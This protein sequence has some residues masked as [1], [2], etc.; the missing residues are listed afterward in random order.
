[1]LDVLETRDK[2]AVIAW[3]A[4]ARDSGLLAQLEEVTTDMWEGYGTAVREALGGHI[5]IVVDRFHVM[6]HF[7]DLLVRARREIQHTLPKEA[8]AALKGSRWLWVTNAE[9]LTSEQREQLDRLKRQFPALGL[10]SEHRDQLR[11]IFEEREIKTTDV[12][13]F[14][15]R[16]LVPSRATI[17]H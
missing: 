6:K 15:L 14:C 3:L 4:A 17:G 7:Q 12:G 9:N 2:P 5:R 8:A 1:M 10:L 13:I 11:Q 16:E